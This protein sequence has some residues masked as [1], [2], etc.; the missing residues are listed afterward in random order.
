MR[1]TILVLDTP[2]FVKTDTVGK[3]RLENLPGGKYV[4]KAWLD[5]STVWERS[6]ELEEGKTLR[7]DFEKK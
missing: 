6:V 2:Y 5:E 3:Y 4:L 7:V 1:G